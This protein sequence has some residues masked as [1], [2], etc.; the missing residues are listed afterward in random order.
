MSRHAAAGRIGTLL[1]PVS[2]LAGFD[3]RTNIALVGGI[4]AKEVVVVNPRQRH[5]TYG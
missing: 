4:A 1:E 3:W 2:Q 5:R